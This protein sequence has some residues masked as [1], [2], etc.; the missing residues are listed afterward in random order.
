MTITR[1]ITVQRA[2]DL[3]AENMGIA[4]RAH[5]R[6]STSGPYDSARWVDQNTEKIAMARALK[7]QA[8]ATM[9]RPIR[10]LTAAT[11]CAE[12]GSMDMADFW[13][14]VARRIEQ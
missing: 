14:N 6:L 1:P 10:C 4:A 9:S 2:N 5:E 7:Y 11:W 3:V 12:H 8:Y 13:A